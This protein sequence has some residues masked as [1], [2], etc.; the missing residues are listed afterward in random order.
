MLNDDVIL[1]RHSKHEDVRIQLTSGYDYNTFFLT[2]PQK[3]SSDGPRNLGAWL[4]PDGNN[5]NEIAH[6]IQKGTTFSQQK[7]NSIGTHTKRGNAGILC[8]GFAQLWNTLSAHRPL[9]PHL[10]AQKVIGLLSQLW[11]LKWVLALTPKWS[12][13]LSPRHSWE[14]LDSLKLVILTRGSSKCI[15]LWVIWTIR[16]R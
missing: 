15:C 9:V 4:A 12:H 13:F 10:I 16:M 8:H 11:F 5:T 6:L 1:K 3:A 7:Y 14:L 2:I